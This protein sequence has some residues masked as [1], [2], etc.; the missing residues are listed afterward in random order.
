MISKQEI[1]N[2]FK[3]K[4]YFKCEIGT[5]QLS[6]HLL[7]NFSFVFNVGHFKMNCR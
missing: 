2:L 4:Q 7:T 1:F 6:F 5:E 3:D